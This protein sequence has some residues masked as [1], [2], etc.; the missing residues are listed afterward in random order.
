[1]KNLRW[2]ALVVP[3]AMYVFACT[4]DAA[5]FFGPGGFMEE[6]L[7]FAGWGLVLLGPLLIYYP[8][9][10]CAWLANPL[11]FMSIYWLLKGRNRAS[12]V[13]SVF[14]TACSLLPLA[15]LDIE[16]TLRW[17]SPLALVSKDGSLELRLGYAL[18]VGSHLLMLLATACQW[19][20]PR[21]TEPT[22]CPDRDIELRD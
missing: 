15:M 5:W 10:F 17:Q 12:L 3:F 20:L 6:N 1:M 19:C 22:H 4:Q 8:L 11:F 9:A 13:A 16:S 18:W 14:A 2:T 7:E 21:E